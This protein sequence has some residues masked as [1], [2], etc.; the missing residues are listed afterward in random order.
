LHQSVRVADLFLDHGRIIA[1]QGRHPESVQSY[2]ARG[3]DIVAGLPLVVVVDG[4]SASAAEV[5]AAALKD[6]GRAVVVGT[7]SY[8]KGTVQTVISLANS[9]ELTLTWSRLITPSGYL[10]QGHGVLPSICTSGIRGDQD[11]AVEQA[12]A[13]RSTG[14]SASASPARA[15]PAERRN[16]GLELKIARRL[17]GDRA[18][19]VQALDPTPDVADARY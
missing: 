12:I 3:R 14:L 16:D 1:T 17:L 19:Y 15:C 6:R 5:V 11:T 8:G 10:L 13:A 7:T 4:G 18:I 9:G 2:E